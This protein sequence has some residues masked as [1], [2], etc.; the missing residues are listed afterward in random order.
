MTNRIT[1]RPSHIMP[2]GHTIVDKKALQTTVYV[3]SYL[4]NVEPELVHILICELTLKR[5]PVAHW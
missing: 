5:T 3:L 4:N 1:R 2:C